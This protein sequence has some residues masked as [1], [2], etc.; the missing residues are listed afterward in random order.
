MISSSD[1]KDFF[2]EETPDFKVKKEA[3]KDK[4]EKRYTFQEFLLKE[5]RIT[6]LEWKSLDD[7]R[8][9]TMIKERKKESATE[10]TSKVSL[11][12]LKEKRIKHLKTTYPISESLNLSKLSDKSLS[13]NTID[14]LIIKHKTK[15]HSSKADSDKRFLLNLKSVDQEPIN[16]TKDNQRNLIEFDIDQMELDQQ[17]D[18]ELKPIKIANLHLKPNRNR[19]NP[20]LQNSLNNYQEQKI[21]KTKRNKPG[22]LSTEYQP[23]SLFNHRYPQR[24]R[25]LNN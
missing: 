1:K 15:L 5:K 12:S 20:I 9:R 22:S 6:L 3:I 10:N 7:E 11:S 14:D 13:N 2:R 8:L 23:G 17:I 16:K 19:I 25:K 21:K 18:Y 4:D 24:K